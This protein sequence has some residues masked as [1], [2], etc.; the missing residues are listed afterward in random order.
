MEL[1][2]QW[3]KG[4][5]SKA[6]EHQ[7]LLKFYLFWVNLFPLFSFC[8]S[9]LPLNTPLIQVPSPLSFCF[10]FLCQ[11]V[12]LFIVKVSGGFQL[13]LDMSYLRQDW[14]SSEVWLNRASLQV[15]EASE[16]FGRNKLISQLIFHMP[17]QCQCLLSSWPYRQKFS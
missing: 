5:L 16:G 6:C 11:F 10:I 12:F 9:S 14:C 1:K 2:S 13:Q 8:C 7:H 15:Q 3:E 4:Y 17:N